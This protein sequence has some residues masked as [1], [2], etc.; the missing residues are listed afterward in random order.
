MFITL[1]R[2]K[3][4]FLDFND[5]DLV[6]LKDVMKASLAYLKKECNNNFEQTDYKRQLHTGNRIIQLPEKPINSIARVS[7]GVDGLT[8]SNSLAQRALVSFDGEKMKLVT[9]ISGTTNT[10]EITITNQT[11]TTLA[12]AISAL[13]AYGWSATANASYGLYPA[14]D[15]QVITGK[16]AK[17]TTL[18]TY[19]E[20]LADYHFVPPQAL[21]VPCSWPQIYGLQV[22]YNAGFETC[23]DDLAQLIAEM[24]QATYYQRRVNPNLLSESLGSYSYTIAAEKGF[25]QLSVASKRTLELYR[26]PRFH[27]QNIV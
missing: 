26:C 4:A 23:P 17:N 8:V 21:Y 10:S 18:I 22:S 2:V 9:V 19:S 25:N 14:S 16:S 5:D 12:G 1:D 6:I 20:D 15:L 11:L 7:S 13:S 24:C 27:S 3:E